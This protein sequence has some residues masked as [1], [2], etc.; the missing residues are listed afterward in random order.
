MT[1]R[2]A[3]LLLLV[4]ANCGESP[5]A[6]PDAP[7]CPANAEPG[8]CWP[9]AGTVPGGS[10]KLGAY[11]PF[12]AMP[13]EVEL[14]YGPQG[15][16]HVPANALISAMPPGDPSCLFDPQ[17]PR[18]RFRGFYV[19]DVPAAPAT[20]VFKAGEEMNGTISCP[21][22][23]AYRPSATPDTF[24]LVGKTGVLFAVGIDEY[25]LIF[26]QKIR[27]EVEVIGANGE[28]ARDEKIVIPRPPANWPP[29]PTP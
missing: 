1:S 7:S 18:T 2:W 10:I 25:D 24:E 12:T 29:D 15:G 21:I 8:P 20:P 16:F 23:I 27:I 9:V 13:D 22:R 3:P 5:S 14:E 6:V 4:A 19:E 11:Q 17:N 26:G 28:Y